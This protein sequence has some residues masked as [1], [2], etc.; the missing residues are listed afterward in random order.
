MEKRKEKIKKWRTQKQQDPRERIKPNPL[1]LAAATAEKDPLATCKVKRAILP[2]TGQHNAKW[3][4]HHISLMFFLPPKP[5]CAVQDLLT[6]CQETPVPEGFI[7]V[8]G[9]QVALIHWQVFAHE[10]W[11]VVTQFPT[12]RLH[13]REIFNTSPSAVAPAEQRQVLHTTSLEHDMLRFSF[14]GKPPE[15]MKKL[16]E[17]ATRDYSC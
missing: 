15:S 16:L 9:D 6:S 13:P 14:T 3:R 12:R 17:H 11:R 1:V 2:W 8:T 5:G 4:P 10:T 7:S